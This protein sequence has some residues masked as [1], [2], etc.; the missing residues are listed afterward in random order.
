MNR[1][2]TG[3]L[4]LGTAT[5]LWGQGSIATS[6]HN[7]SVLGTGA[8]KATSETGI[9]I[10][11]HTTHNSS[12]TA[13]L[14]NRSDNTA[15]YTLYGS[16]S[17]DA[18]TQQPLTTSRLCLSCHDGTV[19][20]G[21][22]LNRV[23]PI[24]FPVG[25]D[26]IPVTYR[27]NLSDDLGDDHPLNI[28]THPD[29]YTC[30][31]CHD[32]QSGTTSNLEC[33]SCHDAHDN[34]YGHFLK[35]DPLNGGICLQ[36]HVQTGWSAAIHNTSSATWN[37]SLPDPWPYT[38]WTTVAA[39]G[40]NNCHT[41]HG[42]SSTYWLLKSSAEEDNCLVCHNGNVA[43]KNVQATL[44]KS[45]T[46]PVADYNSIHL[47][48]EDPATMSLHV[49]C[50]DCHAPH[51]AN[52][53]VA[54]PPDVPGCLTGVGGIDKNGNTV[55]TVTYEYEVCLKCHATV[56][57]SI[58]TYVARVDAQNS[59]RLE[60]AET[61]PSYHPVFGAGKNSSCPS[62]ITP[63]TENSLIYCSDCHGNDE[64]GVGTGPAGPHGSNYAPLLAGQMVFDDYNIESATIYELCYRCHDRNSILGNQ[65]FIRHRL[66]VETNQTS[67]TTC[68]DPHGSY[69]NSRLINFNPDYVT[70]GSGG[71]ILFD[72]ANPRK[73]RCY[74]TCHGEI[75]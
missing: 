59:I 47:P 7:L 6:K 28:D 23:D 62:L 33:T 30:T 22:V 44:L 14:W 3:L 20:L 9:C 57:P 36:C 40:C 37:S 50:S 21:S 71:Q 56:I 48:G 68:H 61:N 42:A 25:F 60:Y 54:T 46:H 58:P 52:S 72:D 19:A 31:G 43:A 4:A 11:C 1:I 41:S 74:L 13:P 17:M 26:K 35:V 12:A 10:F 39:N 16:P 69:N 65:S 29:G 66:H 18:S 15:T 73:L 45:S 24:A 55:T 75:H 32:S 51:Q 70:A 67:C 5:L 49:E 63:Y 27:S 64:A 2:I 38:D 53:T 8:I 34:T